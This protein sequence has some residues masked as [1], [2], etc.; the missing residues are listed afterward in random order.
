LYKYSQK[1][2][3][4]PSQ[5]WL[6]GLQ[7]SADEGLP[8]HPEYF[9]DCQLSN[10]CP[11]PAFP[12]ICIFV[13]IRGRPFFKDTLFS[14]GI[15]LKAKGKIYHGFLLFLF[16]DVNRMQAAKTWKKLKLQPALSA[17]ENAERRSL[18]AS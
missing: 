11:R 13:D 6:N 8:S 10:G 4:N 14:T 12:L 3:L 15:E 2:P 18:A 17:Q 1:H 16:Q 5:P 7:T 9:G